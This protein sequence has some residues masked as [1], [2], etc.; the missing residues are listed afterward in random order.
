MSFTVPLPPRTQLYNRSCS[1]KH[2]LTPG[3][4]QRT[5]LKSEVSV[6]LRRLG[7][8]PRPPKRVS[9]WRAFCGRITVILGRPWCQGTA[10]VPGKPALVPAGPARNTRESVVGH[11]C[12]RESNCQILCRS[13][14]LLVWCFQT[15][16]TCFFVFFCGVNGSVRKKNLAA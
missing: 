14:E 12:G 1:N 3:D 5:N 13:L 2:T 4:S 7:V 16:S 15:Q 9:S 11:F 6:C 10:L 8:P